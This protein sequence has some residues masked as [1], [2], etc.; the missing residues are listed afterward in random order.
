MKK[1][2][3]LLCFVF[4]FMCGCKD[5]STV[6]EEKGEILTNSTIENIVDHAFEEESLSEDQPIFTTE[7]TIEEYCHGCY[8]VS[9]NDGM[10]YGV[11]DKKGNEIV[12]VK[13]DNIY[14]L[15][16]EEIK[17]G[18]DSVLYMQTKYENEYT[19]VTDT[20]NKILDEEVEYTTYQ[21]GT[22]TDDSYC[23]VGKNSRSP[24]TATSLYKKDGSFITN[25]DCSNLV[26]INYDAKISF[27]GGIWISENNYIITLI[28]DLG[29]NAFEFYSV[30]LNKDCQI[31][32][33]WPVICN[34][35]EIIDNKLVLHI[36]TNREYKEYESYSIDI[37]G[38]VQALGLF[39]ENEASKY[40]MT[41]QGKLSIKIDHVID[42]PNDNEQR[43]LFDNEKA[44]LYASNDTWKLVDSFG[45]TLYDE[46][47]YQCAM[48]DDGYL[49]M[50]EDNQACLV[51]RNG[52]MLVDYGYLIYKND[53]V[54]FKEIGIYE[55]HFFVGDDG[56]SIVLGSDVYFFEA[57]KMPSNLDRESFKVT[58]VQENVTIENEAEFLSEETANDYIEITNYRDNFA[59]V[60][61]IIGM[62]E[63]T[64]AATAQ[65]SYCLDNFKIAWT[66]FGYYAAS[67]EG[68]EGITL[69]GVNI[70]TERENVLNRIQ[71]YPYEIYSTEELDVIYL[72]EGEVL[73]YIEMGYV[74][75][76]VSSWYINNYEEGIDI[77]EIKEKLERND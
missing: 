37:N 65:Y 44:K 32:K 3:V 64:E 47:Y 66:D 39:Q 28:E 75:G 2:L 25:I 76:V 35:Y 54:Y 62:N 61:E 43:I 77:A 17:A 19:V 7:Y 60:V 57:P 30:L 71:N 45:N 40:Y 22:I 27:G 29:D 9:K 36:A 68:K 18:K 46:R 31:L 72:L 55:D 5:K 56:V 51:D 69:F 34:N 13:Y 53:R 73:N 16:E 70:G 10:L 4:I 52:R 38:N 8:I 63:N 58:E 67:N 1:I 41:D 33:V 49:L 15:N 23:F 42:F 26:D 21:L 48:V 24:V 6:E 14:F 20:G 50:N 59:E 74:D 11:L 12:P